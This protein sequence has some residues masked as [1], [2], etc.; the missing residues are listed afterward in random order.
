MKKLPFIPYEEQSRIERYDKYTSLREGNH[1]A[2]FQKY[3]Q[4]E[5][6]VYKRDEK[7]G[8]P[9]NFY[10]VN[11]P[12]EITRISADLLFDER[13]KIESENND[14]FIS[15]CLSKLNL[16]ELFYESL[17]YGS[18]WGDAVFKVAIRDGNLTLDTVNPKYYFPIYDPNNVKS[19]PERKE[20][21]YPEKILSQ[22]EE[23]DAA[24]VEIHEKGVIAFKVVILDEDGLQRELDAVEIFGEDY[25]PFDTG[26]NDIETVIHIKNSGAPTD[27]WGVSDYSDLEDLFF[28]L[29]NRYSRVDSILDKHSSPILVGPLN[30]ILDE[31]GSLRNVDVIE[32]MSS[33]SQNTVE[34]ISW[35]GKLTDAFNQ[36]NETI[37]FILMLSNI[38]PSLVGR[39]D[40]ESVSAES[41]RALKLKLIRT[42]SMKHRKELYW[43][44]GIMT[45]FDTLQ[46]ISN[47]QKIGVE[48]VVSKEPEKVNVEWKDGIISDDI[49]KLN[50]IEKKLDNNLI[51]REKAI[52][53]MADVDK[54]T[55]QRRLE[56]IRE[57]KQKQQ[58]FQQPEGFLTGEDE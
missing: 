25:Q 35:D 24:L 13:P 42:L 49:E 4:K 47:S 45:I 31:R 37:D 38:T 12:R 2:V 52:Q 18:A 30:S 56:E 5:G 9:A 58:Q 26:L 29:D 41:G 28:T 7:M 34:Y 10:A 27:Y 44:Q 20:I 57:E 15:S 16:W 43:G 8:T 39:K 50:T 19:T 22:G 55:A 23:I 1:E 3:L 46:K 54:S 40:G 48:G 11:L 21:W 14:D 51:S 36:I 6:S 33:Q 53:E 32:L 17:D